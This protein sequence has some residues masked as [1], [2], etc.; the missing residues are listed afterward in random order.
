LN[1]FTQV[2]L[3]I[4]VT[5]WVHIMGGNYEIYIGGSE[6]YD[7]NVEI[8]AISEIY[9]LSASV[10]FVSEGRITRPSIA[11][12]GQVATERNFPLVRITG[13]MDFVHHPE[14]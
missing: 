11:A 5:F 9:E 12:I 14:F 10:Y 13:F 7:D 6:V 8:I 1:V 4:V 2:L 3:A